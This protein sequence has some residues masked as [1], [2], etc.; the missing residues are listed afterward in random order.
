[1]IKSIYFGL[2]LILS[3]NI[4]ALS[5]DNCSEVI[6][7]TITASEFFIP[8]QGGFSKLKSLI[9]NQALKDAV[10]QATGTEIRDFSSLNISS[11]NGDENENF[12]NSQVSK[13]KGIIQSYNI[14]SEKI[15]NLG[16]GKVLEVIVDA[17]VCVQDKSTT[18][19]VLLIG[20]FTYK[21]KKL[22]NLRSIMQSAF[23]QQSKSFEL[24]S[25][26]PA[27]SYYD[28]IVTGKI[29]NISKEK[30]IDRK[31]MED[32]QGM[33]I[34][35]GFLGAMNK[36]KDQKNNPLSGIFDS[37]KNNSA[38]LNRVVV[39]IN[40]SVSANH[41][42]DNRNYTA[43]ASSE[44]EVSEDSV[45]GIISSLIIEATKDASKNLYIKLNSNTEEFDITN[46]LDY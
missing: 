4:L 6:K 30:K 13:T 46:L 23:S 37:A 16:G 41:K 43:T 44:K 36:G 19:D 29:D 9:I 33:A 21:N 1:M 22:S 38:A 8:G 27:S 45:K 32:Q 3:Q 14:V 20:D 11:L 39:K 7:K 31:T 15:I 24:G 40:V 34:F 25:G 26:D 2:L 5:Q 18:K 10:Q 35:Q 42:T 17:N 12:G 28:I